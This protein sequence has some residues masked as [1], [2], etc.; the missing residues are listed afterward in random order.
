MA[1]RGLEGDRPALGEAGQHDAVR[2]YPRFAFLRDQPLDGPLRFQ[3]VVLVGDESVAVHPDVVPGPH[4]HSGVDGDRPRRCVREDEPGPLPERPEI[5]DNGHEVVAVGAEPVQPDDGGGGRASMRFE[6][7]GRIEHGAHVEANRGAA[8]RSGRAPPPGRGGRGGRHGRRVPTGSSPLR[9]GAGAMRVK[10]A[11]MQRERR[12][13]GT[14]CRGLARL[15][16]G[17]ATLLLVA[18][19]GQS[20][21]LRLPDRSSLAAPSAAPERASAAVAASPEP[22]VG[23]AS[24][25]SLAGG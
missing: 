8:Q 21:P 6:D 3:E 2:R 17:C 25:P 11:S 7:D 9:A 5:G 18:G 12:G 15:A 1:K 20:G 23:R 24:A 10:E 19:C 16:A 4:R 13:P 14:R 22:R